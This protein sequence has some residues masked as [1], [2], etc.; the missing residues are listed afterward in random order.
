MG[1][2]GSSLFRIVIVQLTGIQRAKTFSPFQHADNDRLILESTCRVL[3]RM[4]C[5]IQL[6]TEEQVGTAAIHT[7]VVFSMCQGARAN[8]VLAGDE[9]QG[10][11]IINSPDAVKACHRQN[12]YPLLGPDCDLVPTTVLVDT[13]RPNGELTDMMRGRSSVW[14]KRG[15]VHS[16]Q[17][18]D[19]ARVDDHD[20]CVSLLSDFAR[21]GIKTAA[22]QQHVQGQVIKFYGVL[23][24]SFFR[25]YTELDRKV[26]PMAFG[27]QRDTIETLVRRLGLEVYGGDAV[28]RPDGRVQI[29]D[30][31]D[32][33]SY[34]YYREEAAEA[35]GARIFSRAMEHAEE[36]MPAS[37]GLPVREL[38]RRYFDKT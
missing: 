37:R 7:D 27:R 2:R 19:V 15:D 10:R 22:V 11:L 6:L 1:P 29:I 5:S 16:T 23:G 26:S 13:M 28:L 4:G 25:Y 35:I 17:E 21:R 31:N 9:E 18:G 24:T 12:L 3:R 38:E 30:V 32:W 20:R 8:D 33:P 36:T 14:I 34:A